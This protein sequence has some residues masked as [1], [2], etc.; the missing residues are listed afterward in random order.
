MVEK[1]SL[2][3]TSLVGKSGRMLLTRVSAATPLDRV[4]FLLRT[5]RVL[6]ILRA[7]RA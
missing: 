3:F 2:R 5:A 6:L 4:K 7:F 1:K